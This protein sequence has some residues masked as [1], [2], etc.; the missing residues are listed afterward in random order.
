MFGIQGGLIEARAA[1][2]A[3]HGFVTFALAYFGYKD[4]PKTPINIDLEYFIEAVK[5]FASHERVYSSG[6]GYIGASAGGQIALNVGAE[7]PLVRA[8][9]AISTPHLMFFPLKYKGETRGMIEGLKREYCH[10]NE[11]NE[12]VSIEDNNF[13]PDI[14]N[15]EIPVE[16]IEGKIMLVTGDDDK[17][18]NTSD[19]ARKMQRRLNEHG[20][21]PA[22][23]HHYPG[24]GHLIEVPYM[25]LCRIAYFPVYKLYVLLGGNLIEHSAAQ[26]HAW[27]AIK[28]FLLQNVRDV[29]SNL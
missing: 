16:K 22:T 10:I 8:L 6:I 23:I 14:K 26:E 27:R 3:S 28:K 13:D 2:L 1:I 5:W 7:C 9:V 4:L 24:A 25:P 29:S 11:K 20:K 12:V 15:M 18:P 17:C 21:K 19:H